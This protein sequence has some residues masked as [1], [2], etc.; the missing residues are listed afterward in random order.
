LTIRSA[1]SAFRKAQLQAK[2]NAELAQQRENLQRLAFLQQES[3]PSSTPPSGDEQQS[4]TQQRGSRDLFQRSR[5]GGPHRP[6]GNAEVDASADV[7][8]AL[9]RTHTLMETELSR[10][11]FAQETLEQTSK[12]LEELSDTYSGLDTLLSSSRNL[13]GSLL[14][15]QKSDT[16]YLET[17][18]WILVSTIIWLLFR[19]LLYGPLWWF[20]WW[21]LRLVSRVLFTVFG[22]S[23]SKG[24]AAAANP[25]SSSSSRPPLKVQPSASKGASGRPTMGQP[26]KGV[27]VGGG[28]GGAKQPLSEQVGRM[29]EE[30]RQTDPGQGKESDK[31]PP[32]RGDGEELKPSNDP[33]NPKKRMFEEPSVG[34]GQKKDEL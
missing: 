2:R 14:R 30:S 27:P 32:R 26:G 1:R 17:A 18:F 20:V 3:T 15:S 25:A 22:I 34:G 23:S 8:A 7:T 5:P 9:R 6:T 24:V 33:P 28:G 4:Q 10:S 21:P 19:R 16:W 31:A 11:R 12:A 29:A 13:L